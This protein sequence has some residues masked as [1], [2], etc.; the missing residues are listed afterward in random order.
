MWLP[1]IIETETIGQV[2]VNRAI[3]TTESTQATSTGK[4]WVLALDLP[5]QHVELEKQGGDPKQEHGHLAAQ[6]TVITPSSLV[7]KQLPATIQCFMILKSQ[8]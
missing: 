3:G 4:T 7:L 1:S 5:E 8:G 2:A 6:G